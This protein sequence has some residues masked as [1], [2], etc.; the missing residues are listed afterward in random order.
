VPA[1]NY[2]SIN[3]LNGLLGSPLNGDWTI[4]IVDNISADNGYLFSWELNFDPSVPQEDF[5]FVP[6]I[7]SQSWD[8]DATITAVNG[9]IISI[10]PDSAGE[11]CYTF[12][13]VDV[14]GCEYTEEVCVNVTPE[15][16]P[17]NT[18]YED[19]DGDG[20]GDPNS[21]IEDCSDVPPF[22]YVANSLDC[23]DSS[24]EINPD[25]NDTEGNGIDENCDGVDGNLLGVD[26][27][28]LNEIK[29]LSNPFYDSIVISVPTLLIG[30]QLNV[31]I[32]DLN[33]RMVY[34]KTHSNSNSQITINNLEALEKSTYFLEISN[35][36][37]G[38]NVVKK[39]IKL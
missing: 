34:E 26:D 13:T 16:V 33:G 32:Y 15:G 22:G 39:L 9:N 17:P 4:R 28:S 11:F 1:G 19:L 25:A 20:Y 36:K 3:P 7:T 14:F 38:L 2:S 21:T 5:S 35:E 29:I 27:I 30:S 18:F 10:A 23:N 31:T 24:D 8:S 37:V 12:R 6:S